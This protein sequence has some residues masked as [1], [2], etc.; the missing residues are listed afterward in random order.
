LMGLEKEMK[1]T[2]APSWD[3]ISTAGDGATGTTGAGVITMCR[4]LMHI[5]R[6]RA[7]GSTPATSV[8]IVSSTVW[9]GH[10]HGSKQPQ[11]GKQHTYNS[12][13]TGCASAPATEPA[14]VPSGRPTAAE[15]LNHADYP[16]GGNTVDTEEIVYRFT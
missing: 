8:T 11:R 2:L 4:S 5:A 9:A 10:Q 13:H 12:M 7:T 15:A 14:A 3:S 16:S 1:D 6:N